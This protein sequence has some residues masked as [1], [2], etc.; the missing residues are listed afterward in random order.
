LRAADQK[1][2][3]RDTFTMEQFT[4]H[5]VHVLHYGKLSKKEAESSVQGEHSSAGDADKLFW[6]QGLRHA[7]DK[8]NATCS[9]IIDSWK[10]DQ[11]EESATKL[12]E[13]RKNFQLNRLF[14]IGGNEH[15]SNDQFARACRLVPL[16]YRNSIENA[17]VFLSDDGLVDIRFEATSM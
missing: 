11:P 8:L 7:Y 14:E 13:I 10:L 5:G 4:R 3:V 12:K 17:F 9:E 6:M 16:S 15:L 1:K 2:A